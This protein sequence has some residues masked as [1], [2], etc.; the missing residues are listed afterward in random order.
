MMAR[1][2]TAVGS[3]TETMTARG[4]M[5]IKLKGHIGCFHGS[6]KSN[7]TDRISEKNLFA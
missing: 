1:G 6:K 3:T 4:V 7:R 2:G 5:A